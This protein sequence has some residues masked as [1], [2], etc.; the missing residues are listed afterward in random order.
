[1]TMADMTHTASTLTQVHVCAYITY[2]IALIA[3]SEE[4]DIKRL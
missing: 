3:V 2:N 4:W 1:M